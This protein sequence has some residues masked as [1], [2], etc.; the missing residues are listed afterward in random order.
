MQQARLLPR[1]GTCE[2]QA[3]LECIGLGRTGAPGAGLQHKCL[4]IPLAVQAQLQRSVRRS[5]VVLS[6]QGK[7]RNSKGRDAGARTG[8]QG[9]AP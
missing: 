4:A 8:T 6:L 5:T 3:V 9:R 2:R 7:F 1:K